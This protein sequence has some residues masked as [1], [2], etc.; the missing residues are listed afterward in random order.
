LTRCKSAG[1]FSLSIVTVVSK[2]MN[3]ITLAF[4][5]IIKKRKVWCGTGVWDCLQDIRDNRPIIGDSRKLKMGEG[6]DL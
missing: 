5:K 4:Q 2:W 6:S 1:S 3:R